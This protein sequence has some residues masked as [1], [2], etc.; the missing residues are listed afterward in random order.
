MQSVKQEGHWLAELPHESKV[1]FLA[2]LA[3][4]LTVVARNSY[5]PQTEE[6]DEPSQL[7]SVNEIQH[8]ILACL[9][10]SLGGV[11][12]RS[13]QESIASLVLQQP[14]PELGGLMEFAWC[15]TKERLG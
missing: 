4:E 3:H 10:Q 14:D 6:L 5:R 15:R 1:L 11:C 13:F 2:G 8:R 12:E 9:V 7:R